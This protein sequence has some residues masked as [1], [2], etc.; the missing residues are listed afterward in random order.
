M[1]TRPTPASSSPPLIEARAPTR[2]ATARPHMTAVRVAVP[3]GGRQVEALRRVAG[4][5]PQGEQ[6]RPHST[7]GHE[8]ALYRLLR[9][10]WVAE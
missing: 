1:M 6:P 7:V 9:I 5:Q 10:T 4:G 8:V 3:P 2:W